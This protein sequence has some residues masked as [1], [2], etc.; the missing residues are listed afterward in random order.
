MKKLDLSF[1]TMTNYDTTFQNVNVLFEK[2]NLQYTLG[3]VL[4]KVDMTQVS[5]AETEKYPHV[6]LFLS[7]IHI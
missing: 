1:F 6:T 2:D 7:L 5:I 3:E 4:S